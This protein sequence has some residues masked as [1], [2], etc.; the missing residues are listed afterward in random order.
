MFNLVL[1]LHVWVFFFKKKN[2]V[3]EK[4]SDARMVIIKVSLTTLTLELCVR[5]LTHI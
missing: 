5:S 3:E 4:I 1:Y 2:V